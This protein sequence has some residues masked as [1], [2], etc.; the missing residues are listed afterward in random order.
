MSSAKFGLECYK[1]ITKSF[2]VLTDMILDRMPLELVAL[3]LGGTLYDRDPLHVESVC[4]SLGIIDQNEK[5]YVDKLVRRALIEGGSSEKFVTE[6][7]TLLD[8]NINPNYAIEK[9]RKILR[10]LQFRCKLTLPATI[11]MAKLLE[12]TNIAIVSQG[13]MSESEELIIRS[14]KENGVE[15]PSTHTLTYY[16]RRHDNEIVSKDESLSSAISNVSVNHVVFIGD[17]EADENAAKHVGCPFIKFEPFRSMR[18]IH[19]A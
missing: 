16:G 7:I 18:L 14:F 17:S 9:K 1:T 10:D 11:M 4:I 6:V 5:K 19:G 3:D 8:L 13:A 15:L 2:S 12:S